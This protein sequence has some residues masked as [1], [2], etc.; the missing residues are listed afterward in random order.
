MCGISTFPATCGS[1]PAT[2]RRRRSKR[3]NPPTKAIRPTRCLAFLATLLAGARTCRGC[4]CSFGC[5]PGLWECSWAG[6]RFWRSQPPWGFST[7]RRSIHRRRHWSPRRSIGSVE[8]PGVNPPPFAPRG[9]RRPPGRR[10][11]S[12]G[13]SGSGAGRRGPAERRPEVGVGVRAGG[14]RLSERGRSDASRTGHL[15]DPVGQQRFS[16][17]R[18]AQRPRGHPAVAR[19]YRPLANGGD[20][21]PGDGIQHRRLGRRSQPDWRRRGGGRSAVGQRAQAAPPRRGRVD[22]GR[23][24]H[25]VGH[26]PDW[27]RRGGGRSAVD[28]QA[29]APPPGRGQVDRGRAGRRSVIARVEPGEGTP[30]FKFPTIEPPSNRDYADSSQGHANISVFRGQAGGGERPSGPVEVLLDGKGQS[31]AD[32]LSESFFFANDTSGMVLLDLG[33]CIGVKKVNTYSWHQHAKL[34]SDR[35]RAMQ[36]YCLY[37]SSRDAARRGRR[38]GGRR[39]DVDRPCE[40]RRVLWLSRGGRPACPAGGFHRRRQRRT[41]WQVSLLALGRSADAGPMRSGDP[42]DGNQHVSRRVRCVCSRKEP[43]MIEPADKRLLS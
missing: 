1:G 25:A 8:P 14:D 3:G 22:R 18:A 36:K 9:V 26:R 17:D 20:R 4:G 31:Q 32:A 38:P 7:G 27:R 2:R 30:A 16:H 10:R 28:Q 6:Q 5:S 37:G 21:G 15:R 29:R 34:A 43:G 24:G 13:R 11:L 23:A 39:L 35:L 12:M 33:K 19:V 41:D 42:A 40:H